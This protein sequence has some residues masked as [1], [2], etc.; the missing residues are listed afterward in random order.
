MCCLM[1]FCNL[2]FCSDSARRI[3]A[4]H[5]TDPLRAQTT[6]STFLKG[7]LTPTSR[8]PEKIC[9][10]VGMRS[11]IVIRDISDLQ[12]LRGRSRHRLRTSLSKIPRRER[13][14]EA[15]ALFVK[16]LSW[17][18]RAPVICLPITSQAGNKIVPAGGILIS[19][20]RVIFIFSG[21]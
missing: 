6:I 21:I 19:N 13:S 5:R 8:F 14:L 20:I 1:L 15:S 16:A 3:S 9:E 4:I 12:T 18:F 17:A 11:F 10:G 7:K 2:H